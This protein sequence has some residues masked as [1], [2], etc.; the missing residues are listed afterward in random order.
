M[1]SHSKFTVEKW[2]AIVNDFTESNSSPKD[3]SKR[4]GV[5][6][7]SIYIWRNRFA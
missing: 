2:S 6:F 7:N 3:Y 1:S 4:T 5:N